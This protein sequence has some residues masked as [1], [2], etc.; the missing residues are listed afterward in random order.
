MAELDRRQL[1]EEAMRKADYPDALYQK[2]MRRLAL[3]NERLGKYQ[4]ASGSEDFRQ[5]SSRMDVKWIEMLRSGELEIQ[6]EK[7][8]FRIRG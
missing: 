2:M 5:S 4:G 3:A 8:G 6:L 7:E 1:Y